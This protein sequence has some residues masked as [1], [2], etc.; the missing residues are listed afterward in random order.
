MESQQFRSVYSIRSLS[1]AAGDGNDDDVSKQEASYSGDSSFARIYVVCVILVLLC[2]M[3]FFT[4][5]RYR[6]GRGRANDISSGNAGNSNANS[7]KKKSS[8]QKNILLDELFEAN[9]CKK[10]CRNRVLLQWV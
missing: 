1:V 10:V 3:R 7:E 6:F 5:F 2:V 8:E 4:L 9:T